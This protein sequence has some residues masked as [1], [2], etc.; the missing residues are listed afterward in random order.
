VSGSAEM[1][2]VVLVG[3]ETRRIVEAIRVVADII[4]ETPTVAGGIAVLCRVHRVYRATSDLDTLSYRDH[5][6]TGD[7]DALD[8]S[9]AE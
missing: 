8:R 1:P 6:S 4:G 9:A 7:L 3:D 2:Y 5:R